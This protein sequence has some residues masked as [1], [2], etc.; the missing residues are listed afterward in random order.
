MQEVI[1]QFEDLKTR[2]GTEVGVTDWFTIE[3]RMA[4]VFGALTGNLDARHHG[5]AWAKT[6]PWGGTTAHGMS[7]LGLIPQ[8][9]KECGLPLVTSDYMYTLNYGFER[10]R[11]TA[12]F[13]IGQRA[14][15]HIVLDKIRKRGNHARLAKATYSVESE[16][17][18][19]PCM[20]AQQLSLFVMT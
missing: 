6:S 3:Q 7:I 9:G 16:N 13:R 8:F 5:A 4:D 12:A 18:V 11:F 2:V 1:Q 10:V 19:R 15:A 17:S 14:R 20:G